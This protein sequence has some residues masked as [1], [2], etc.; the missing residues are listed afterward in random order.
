MRILTKS[1]IIA[2]DFWEKMSY[3]SIEGKAYEGNL[4]NAS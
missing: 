2:L 4:E 1:V 3:Y